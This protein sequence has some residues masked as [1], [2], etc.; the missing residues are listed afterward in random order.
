MSDFFKQLLKQ[1]NDIWNR[2]NRGQK[3]ITAAVITLTFIG[4]IVLIVWVGYNG[5]SGNYT[6]L[7]SNLELSESASI[8]EKLKES[9][10]EY[11]IENDG[12]SIL[13]PK[14]SVYEMRMTFAK[15]GLPKS[16]GIGYELFD[17]T[18]LGMTDFVQNLNFKRALEGEL[19]RSIESLDEVD[20]ARVHVVIPK[21][22][23]FIEKQKNATASVVLKLRPGIK[24][25][26][27]QV[28]GIANL[29]AYAVEGL[30]RK[31]I[32]IMDTEGNL[33]SD[34]YGDSELA[35]RT[36][37]QLQLQQKVEQAM[38]RKALE[39]LESVLG[40]NKSQVK[41]SVDL[42]F[43]QITKTQ[44]I[45]DPTSKVVRSE[46]RNEESTANSPQGDEKRENSITNYEMNKTVQNIIGEVG[47]IKRISI[48]A[49]VDGIY[50]TDKEGKRNYVARAAEEI[51][52]LE[53]LVKR[54]VGYDLQR[55][56]Q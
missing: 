21:E 1:I 50:E 5:K 26:E 17:K 28:T 15:M 7:F 20:R 29:V 33:L 14:K 36:S 32:T 52:K 43:E 55:G 22:T 25:N 8:V 54:A 34:A 56:D 51:L 42:N 18:N 48:S 13:V 45:Y 40:P 30:Q 31:S 2:L 6:P 46:E 19:A 41:V 27:K 3:I 4:L 44:E 12:H 35:E 11:Q 47:S 53:E 24:L 23:I 49:A 16:G 9:K 37:S 38:A 10:I 39:M